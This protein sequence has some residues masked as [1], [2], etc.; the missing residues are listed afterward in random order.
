MA[1]VQTFLQLRSP[2]PSAALQRVHNRNPLTNKAAPSRRL[3][4]ALDTFFAPHNA[5]L[6]AW[7]AARGIPWTPWPNASTSVV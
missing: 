5:Q 4:T 2:F 7:L 3:S 1:R 6:Y